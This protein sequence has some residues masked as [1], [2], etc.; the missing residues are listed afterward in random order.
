V[1][2]FC[3]GFLGG[4]GALGGSIVVVFLGVLAACY[5]FSAA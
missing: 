2:L 5:E 3:F 1:I 4:L